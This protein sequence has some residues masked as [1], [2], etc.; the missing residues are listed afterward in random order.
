MSKRLYKELKD[1]ILQ[2]E[3]KPLLENDY[4][5]Y[6]EDHNIRKVHAIIKGNDD[7]VY[8]HKFIRFIIDIPDDYPFVPPIVTFVNYD[9][10]RIH[11]TLYEDGRTCSTILNTWP[12]D[13][14]KWCSS[15]CIETILLMFQS[16]LDNNPYTHEPGGRDND[17]YTDFVLHQTWQTCLIR[18]IY[19]ENIP[20]LFLYYIN[21]YLLKNMNEIFNELYILH[22]KYPDDIYTTTCFYIYDYNM[23][24]SNIIYVLEN[25]CNEY[26]LKQQ[27]HSELDHDELDQYELDKDELDHD[28]LNQDELDQDELDQHELD[29]HEL[30]QHELDQHELNQHDLGKDELDQDLQNEQYNGNIE[31]IEHIHFNCNI[32]YDTSLD[33]INYIKLECNHTFHEYCIKRHVLY[34]GQNCSFCRN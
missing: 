33:D 27:D 7:S 3:S 15:F 16:F 19:D 9:G 11:P 13:N 17:T 30:D 32:C 22:L 28:E 5:I 1:L 12:S 8:R 29:Q 31:N 34:N 6:F 18:Y 21:E 25:Y 20:D 10:V 4:L 23:H 2:Q 24:Y 14:E 26:L